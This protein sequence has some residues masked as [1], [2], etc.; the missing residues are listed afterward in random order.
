MLDEENVPMFAVIE[1][2]CFGSTKWRS[3]FVDYIK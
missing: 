3:K 2:G 1:S